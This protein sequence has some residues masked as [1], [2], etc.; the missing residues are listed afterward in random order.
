MQRADD[1]S[2]S[3]F[4][5]RVVG[6]PIA[7]PVSMDIALRMATLEKRRPG[8]LPVLASFRAALD[9]SVLSAADLG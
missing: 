5:G 6:I 7:P 1:V 3:V 8:S 9:E 2:R 4:E